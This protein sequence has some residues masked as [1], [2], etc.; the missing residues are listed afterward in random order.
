MKKSTFGVIGLG[1]MG[2]NLSLNIAEKGHSLSVYNRTEGNEKDIV[3][4]FLRTNT[5][6]ENIAG[7]TDLSAFIN[8]LQ[9]PR[10]ILLM[11]QAGQVIDALLDKLIPLLNTN[12]VVIDGG[13]SHYLDT[14]RRVE[15]LAK[16]QI[17]FIGAGISGGAT[18]ARKGPSIMP[19]GHQESYDLIASILESIAAKDKNGKPCCTFIGKDG[20]GHF[21][22]MVHNGIEY[23]EMQLLAECYALM[24]PVFS[25]PEIAIIFKTWNKGELSSYLLEITA[26]IFKQKEKDQY[27]LDLILDKAGNKGTGS[28]SSKT[29]LDLGFPV[30]MMSDA[31]FAR[32]LSAFKE[33][34]VALSQ[35]RAKSAE[36]QYIINLDHLKEAY[37]FARI[38]NH[39]QGFALIQ[40]ASETYGWQLNL[41]EIA[42][43]WTNGCIIRSALMEDLSSYF[44]TERQ[45]INHYFIF[46]KLEK[47]ETAIQQTLIN[48]LQQR[49]PSPVFA[50]AY[51]YW[52]AM[53]SEQLPANLIQAQRD[54]FGAHTYQRID[55]DW[56]E[57]FHSEWE[58]IDNFSP[59]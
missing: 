52:L 54:Y 22:K 18:G 5:A 7:Y 32:Y 43:I 40:Q 47:N 28:W 15:T 2:S 20:A 9:R 14:Q 58:C 25:Y 24:R 44:Q 23:A 31:V 55:K 10:K 21:I 34:R 27:L 17:H 11:I 26:N 4:D 1:V 33:Q 50:A 3:H 12:D 41:S 38:I 13:N 39:H 57:S 49:L 35:K 8:S 51:Q 6:F 45:L 29:A 53:T 59:S 56:N 48:A 42:R 46:K 36:N 37:Q 19:G 16:S 30:S